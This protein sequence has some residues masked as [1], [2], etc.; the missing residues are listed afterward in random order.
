MRRGSVVVVADRAG[1]DYAGKPR[2]A[3]VVQAE[4]FSETGSVA[5]CLLTSEPTDAPF[6]RLAIE[7]DGQ[8]GLRR[9]SW[10]AVEKLTTLRRERVASVIGQLDAPSMAALDS[11]LAAFLG[12]R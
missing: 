3:V 2:P 8:N 5:V 9:R 1:G 6:L 4:E 12:L 10:V 7:P 11:R